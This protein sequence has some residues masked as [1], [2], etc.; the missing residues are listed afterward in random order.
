MAAGEERFPVAAPRETFEIQG[1]LRAES[2]PQTQRGQVQAIDTTFFFQGNKQVIFTQ[3]RSRQRGPSAA[4]ETD[5]LNVTI[6]VLKENGRVVA[7]RYGKSDYSDQLYTTLLETYRSDEVTRQTFAY[8]IDLSMFSMA[9][10]GGRRKRV[11]RTYKRRKNGKQRSSSSAKRE[12]R[13]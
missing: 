12:K 3:T 7:R 4:G 1:L 11:K 13:D 6:V 10:F 9:Q 5:I 2:I 8:T